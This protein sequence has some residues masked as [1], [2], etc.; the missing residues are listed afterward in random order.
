[1]AVKDIEKY[2]GA[3]EKAVQSYH[4]EKI[5][6]INQIISDL[7]R[8]TYRG[9]DIDT[10]EIRSESET[11]SAVSGRR[12]YNYRVVMKRGNSEIDMR[13]R[14]SAGQ[15]VLASV[16]IRLAVS[17]AFCYECGILALDEPTTNLDEDNAR[18]LAAALQA[19][20][21][22]RRAV[23][24]FQLIIITHDEQFVR[25]LGA[26]TLDRFYYVRKDPEGVFSV[27]EERTFDQLFA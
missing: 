19:L 26:Q 9:S 21:Q 12:S 11:A 22:M 16:I 17:E 8:Q 20:I 15:K 25:A 1:M 24:H 4:Q 10:I 6:Q 13:G 14:C 5:A 7:W 27:I 18:S 2:Y 23:K 3:L